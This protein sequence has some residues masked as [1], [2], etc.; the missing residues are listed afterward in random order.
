MYARRGEL[1][2]SVPSHHSIQ[3]GNKACVVWDKVWMISQGKWRKR[4]RQFP[5]SKEE[6]ASDLS[7][8]IWVDIPLWN[9]EY[10]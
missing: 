7:L 4:S 1:A 6:I 5:H 10:I 8:E 3:Y 2:T 9:K